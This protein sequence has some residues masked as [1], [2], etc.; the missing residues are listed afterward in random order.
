[1]AIIKVDEN[2]NLYAHVGGWVAK[3]E[4]GFTSFKEGDNVKG[5]HFG[6][7]T[8]IG[9]GKLEG[10]GQYAEYWVT[11]GLSIPQHR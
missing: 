11:S 8:R 1:M 2:G 5:F 3:P 6:G 7:T 10:R 4:H 9:M